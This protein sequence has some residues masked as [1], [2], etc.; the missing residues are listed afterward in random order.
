MSDTIIQ[1]ERLILR[2]WLDSDLQAM[3]E[4]TRQLNYPVMYF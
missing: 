1:T 3:A 2:Q 4:S